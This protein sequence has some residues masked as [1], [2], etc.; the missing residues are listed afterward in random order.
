[1]SLLPRTLSNQQCF[2]VDLFPWRGGTVLYIGWLL[3]LCDLEEETS[4]WLLMKAI[5]GIFLTFVHSVHAQSVHKSLFMSGPGC[6]AFLLSSMAW[7]KLSCT[8]SLVYTISYSAQTIRK[9]TSIR[10]WGWEQWLIFQT[11]SSLTISEYSMQGASEATRIVF[12]I[13]S[14]ALRKICRPK[15]SSFLSIS[16]DKV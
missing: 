13:T 9:Q 15:A 14:T 8:L 1:M 6:L 7:R 4:W 5:I 2:Q 11:Q 12:T 16:V 10:S 3:T